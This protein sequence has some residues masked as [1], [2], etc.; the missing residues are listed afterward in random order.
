VF[1]NYARVGLLVMDEIGYLAFD[2]ANADL[3]YQVIAMRY[4]KRSLVLTTNLAFS[5]WPTI[6]PSATSAIALIDRIVHHADVI[7]IEGKSRRLRE[8]EEAKRKPRRKKP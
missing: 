7:Q 1:N 3:L 6:F 2:A 4:E 8:A 5:E